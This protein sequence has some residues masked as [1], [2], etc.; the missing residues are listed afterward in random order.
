MGSVGVAMETL[1]ILLSACIISW[2]IPTVSAA[3][4]RKRISVYNLLSLI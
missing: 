4:K 1:L 2:L 3:G